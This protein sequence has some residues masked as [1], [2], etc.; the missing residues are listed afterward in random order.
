M[1]A[2]NR[3]VKGTRGIRQIILGII[4]GVVGALFVIIAIYFLIKPREGSSVVINYVFIGLGAIAFIA[5]V[6]AII[7]GIKTLKKT[8]QVS[9][10]EKSIE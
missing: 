2:N 10:E 3:S 8:K 5:G 4:F 7:S 6:L 1:E 9:T